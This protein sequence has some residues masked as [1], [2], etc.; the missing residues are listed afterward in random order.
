MSPRA[1]FLADGWNGRSP[2]QIKISRPFALIF[3]AELVLNEK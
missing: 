3:S 2:E 1:K